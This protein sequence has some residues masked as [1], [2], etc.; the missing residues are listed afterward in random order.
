MKPAA[1]LIPAIVVLLTLILGVAVQP[2]QAQNVETAGPPPLLLTDAQEQYRL[3]PHVDILEDTEKRW[4]IEDVASPEFAHRFE[5]NAAET[6]RIGFT[7]SA[8]WI[9]VQ[10]HNDSRRTEW[11]LEHGLAKTQ[12]VDLY[13]PQQD[14]AGFERYQTGLLRP[15]ASRAIATLNYVFPL[16]IPPQ[17]T[18]VL[19]LRFEHSRAT[20][21]PLHLWSPSAFAQN[22]QFQLLQLGISIGILTFLFCSIFIVWYRLRR[23]WILYL[24]LLLGA[25]AFDP[26]IN[27]GIG[28]QYLW[29]QL[30]PSLRFLDFFNAGIIFLA[31]LKTS[32]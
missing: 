8:F 30:G 23:P 5:P 20:Q 13:I 7:D 11:W 1:S 12:F 18:Q 29:P 2:L 17:S 28:H 21:L 6:L 25:L 10:I 14:D 16:S 15:F 3:G 24:S 32:P 19:Y 9:R 4:T 31:F 27:Q 26:V 22:N